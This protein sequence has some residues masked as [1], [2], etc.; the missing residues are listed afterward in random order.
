[1]WVHTA[2]SHDCNPASA[3]EAFTELDS[4]LGVP[5]GQDQRAR[6]AKGLGLSERLWGSARQGIFVGGDCTRH[7]WRRVM[8]VWEWRRG[9]GIRG[10]FCRERCLL[11]LGDAP[12]H[13]QS[14]SY[15]IVA[16]VARVTLLACESIDTAAPSK[17]SVR[18]PR[19]SSMGVSSTAHGA[20]GA[21]CRLSLAGA[22]L[23]A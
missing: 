14:L 9:K 23:G 5:Q 10:D 3:L 7:S 21:E 17:I 15:E 20:S 19:I 4:A 1:M 2:V 22:A 8:K 16:P 12:M 11:R 18:V 13:R 6:A